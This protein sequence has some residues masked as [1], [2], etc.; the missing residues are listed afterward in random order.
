MP[1]RKAGIKD[2]RKNHTNRMRNLDVKTTLK[3]TIKTFLAS[4]E[5]KNKEKA[6]AD[7]KV[8][9]KKLDK[10][11][12]RNILTKNTAARRKSRLARLLANLA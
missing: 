2:L 6:Q 10:A 7:L 9:Y 5:E 8:A 12:K 11:T 1:Q 3:K 4:I